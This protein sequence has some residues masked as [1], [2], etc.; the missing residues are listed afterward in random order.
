MNRFFE[1]FIVSILGTLLL[2]P[3]ILLIVLIK[4]DSKGPVL[5][6]SKRIGKDNCL[7]LMPKFR[8]MKMDTPQVATHLLTNV[9]EYQTKVGRLIRNTSLDEI[10]Q[11]VSVLKGICAWLDQ[12]QLCLI[13]MINS[14]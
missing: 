14:S 7:F 11:I 13:R 8:S 2:I 10:P 6:F 12:D 5:H 1:L 4:F 3:A 9:T